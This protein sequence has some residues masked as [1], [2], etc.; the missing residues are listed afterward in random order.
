MQPDPVL[1]LGQDL[2][3]AQ[4]ERLLVGGMMLPLFEDAGVP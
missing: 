2:T 1:H 4:R 3:E